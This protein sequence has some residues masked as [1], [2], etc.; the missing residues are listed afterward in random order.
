MQSRLK[1]FLGIAALSAGLLLAGCRHGQHALRIG[2]TPGPAE[3]LLNA[4][5]PELVKEGVSLEVVPFTDYVQ[6]NLALASHDLDGNLYQNVPFLEQFNRDHGTHFVTLAKIYV[7]LMAIY[8]GKTKS[9]NG[10]A[11]GARVSLPNDPVNQGRALVLLESAGLLTLRP[12]AGAQ[13]GLSDVTGNPK[14]L[15]LVELDAS[16]LPRS[17]DDVDLAAINAN[18]AL[19]AGLSPT[20]DALLHE[21]ADSIYANVLA[22]NTG[23]ESDTRLSKLGVALRGETARAFIAAHYRGGIV[24]AL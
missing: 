24:P 9:L 5:Q 4:V 17:R 3:E 21:N 14:H 16:Q 18:F 10:L 19:D 15:K 7:P 11:A 13:A 22:A 12:G 2:V 8:P 23:A 20:T 6:P 1:T